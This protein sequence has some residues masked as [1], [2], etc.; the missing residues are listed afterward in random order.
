MNILS[1]LPKGLL[2]YGNY[3]PKYLCVAVAT[4]LVKRYF[5][6]D[7]QIAWHFVHYS[8]CLFHPLP[9]FATLT[10]NHFPTSRISANHDKGLGS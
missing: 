9:F 6:I 10:T 4:R 8:E 5:I 7:Q 1:H 2:D 3:A